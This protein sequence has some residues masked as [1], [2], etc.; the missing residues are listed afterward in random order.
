MAEPHA[1]VGKVRIEYR[2]ALRYD[3]VLTI[4]TPSHRL[5]VPLS[6]EIAWNVFPST[7]SSSASLCASNALLLLGLYR[8]QAPPSQPPRAKVQ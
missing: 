2:D 7:I 5:L 3:A 8:S 6:I 1:C 4:R